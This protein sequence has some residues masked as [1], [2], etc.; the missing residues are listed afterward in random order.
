[1]DKMDNV[2]QTG[3]ERTEWGESGEF[4]GDMREMLK[5]GLNGWK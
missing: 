5:E 4:G 3:D 2:N 1:M